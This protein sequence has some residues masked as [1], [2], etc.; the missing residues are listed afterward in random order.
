LSSTADFRKTP[1]C[2]PDHPQRI[3]FEKDHSK[4]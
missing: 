1:V 3:S 2:N 4:P